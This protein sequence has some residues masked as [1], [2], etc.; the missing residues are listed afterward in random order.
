MAAMGIPAIALMAS[1]ATVAS[2]AD[3]P[4]KDIPLVDVCVHHVQAA[5]V[6]T[7]MEDFM[8]LRL[9]IG[10]RVYR[11]YAGNAPHIRQ[12]L[13][14]VREHPY[15]ATNGTNLYMRQS[16][17]FPSDLHVMGVDD[18]AQVDLI[19]ETSVTNGVCR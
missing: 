14:M 9:T 3:A 19:L 11:V 2:S 13:A 8:I 7:N 10:G 1:A 15:A 4:Y 17:D 5:E 6:E 16:E 12:P 18:P